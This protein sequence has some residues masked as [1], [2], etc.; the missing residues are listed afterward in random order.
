MNAPS[1]IVVVVLAY[2][3]G[4]FCRVGFIGLQRQL[5]VREFRILVVIIVVRDDFLMLLDDVVHR[6][7]RVSVRHADPL[8]RPDSRPWDGFRPIEHI[9]EWLQ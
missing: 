1:A 2:G 9:A 3:A 8:C 7:F 5:A 4:L 6:V